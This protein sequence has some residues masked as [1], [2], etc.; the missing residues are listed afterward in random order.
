MLRSD[1]RSLTTLTDI[2]VLWTGGR[3]VERDTHIV[4]CEPSNP[5]HYWGNFIVFPRAPEGLDARDEWEALFR[6]EFGPEYKH[7][8]FTWNT[9]DGELGDVSSFEARDYQVIRSVAADGRAG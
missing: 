6:R 7:F 8:A 2:D 9:V 4:V 5:S 3:V 1:I